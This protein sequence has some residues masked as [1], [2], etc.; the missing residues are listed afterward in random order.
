[1]SWCSMD[2]MPGLGDHVEVMDCDGGKHIA[3]FDRSGIW[4]NK[5]TD[6]QLS[7]VKWRR[8]VRPGNLERRGE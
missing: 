6:E 4:S 2:T 7:P 8:L 5:D 3:S 1:M